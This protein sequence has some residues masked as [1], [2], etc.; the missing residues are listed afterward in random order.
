MK[1]SN[2][3]I[4]SMAFPTFVQGG[5]IAK[6]STFLTLATTSIPSINTVKIHPKPSRTSPLAR[7]SPTYPHGHPLCNIPNASL[8]PGPSFA[9]PITHQQ[10]GS[11]LKL[12]IQQCR[13]DL[14]SNGT[15]ADSNTNGDETGNG[16]GDIKRG[17]CLST[18]YEDRYTMCLFYDVRVEDTARIEDDRFRYTSWDND[19]FGV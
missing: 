8:Q 2:I 5:N 12:C 1:F 16:S 11:N 3:L 17:K 14:G 15:R 6:S 7:P 9:I 19:C 13:A 18:L 4:P 10:S